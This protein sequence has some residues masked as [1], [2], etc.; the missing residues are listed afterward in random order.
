MDALGYH[1]HVHSC[2]HKPYLES[3]TWQFLTLWVSCIIP[4]KTQFYGSSSIFKLVSSVLV[5]GRI[6]VSI[7]C[8]IFAHSSYSSKTHTVEVYQPFFILTRT[9]PQ[10]THQTSLFKLSIAWPGT[11]TERK[12][13]LDSIFP[14]LYQRNNQKQEE[15][16]TLL[17]AFPSRK[18]WWV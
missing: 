10:I 9:M 15:C 5:K 18:M 16:S 17:L 7:T 1:M 4:W 12:C 13:L 11:S 2:V 3:V 8:L 6:P 14:Y